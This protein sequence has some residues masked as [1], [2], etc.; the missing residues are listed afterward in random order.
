M[1]VSTRGRC[2][3]RMSLFI[4]QKD[5]RTPSQDFAGASDESTRDQAV[6]IDGLAVP[7]DVKTGSSFLLEA[8]FPQ[9][10]RPGAKGCSQRFGPLGL[11]KLAQKPLSVA[12]HI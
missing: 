8:L 12:I 11:G 3:A 2:Q 1:V 10:G 5:Q 4:M 7:I 9:M 6:G